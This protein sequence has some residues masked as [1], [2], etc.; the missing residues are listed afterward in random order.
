MLLSNDKDFFIVAHRRCRAFLS[1]ALSRLTA[2]AEFGDDGWLVSA[3][4]HR[5]EVFF[6]AGRAFLGVS[7][8][9]RAHIW[10]KVPHDIVL[11]LFD[12]CTIKPHERLRVVRI[13]GCTSD[14][15]RG[16]SVL[17]HSGKH[18][19]HPAVSRIAVGP[20]LFINAVR[21]VIQLVEDMRIVTEAGGY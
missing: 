11:A 9:I 18:F 1:C 5:F 21:L 2:L 8:L 16:G 14:D 6:K 3:V 17:P 20:H 12:K 15:D 13:C 7:G 19:K 4:E 10:M